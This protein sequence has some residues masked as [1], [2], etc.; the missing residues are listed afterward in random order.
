MIN[1]ST[2]VGTQNFLE[3][4]QAIF[5]KEDT[6]T[7]IDQWVAMS[8][9]PSWSWYSTV[10]RKSFEHGIP[11]TFENLPEPR[12][13]NK[14]LEATLHSDLLFSLTDIL[15]VFPEM[16]SDHFIEAL[17]LELPS[18]HEVKRI[19]KIQE[20]LATV[21]IIRSAQMPINEDILRELHQWF[22]SSSPQA[23]YNVLVS[24]RNVL[25]S[26][27]AIDTLYAI[28]WQY[29]THPEVYAQ[30]ETH[31]ILLKIAYE[32]S[33]DI[34][35]VGLLKKKDIL[36]LLYAKITDTPSQLIKQFLEAKSV[37]EAIAIVRE[38]FSFFNKLI[39]VMMKIIEDLAS[40]KEDIKYF[41]QNRLSLL[42]ETIQK[43]VRFRPNISSALLQIHNPHALKEVI[44]ANPQI[45]DDSILLSLNALHSQLEVSH[46]SHLAQ[47]VIHDESVRS[48]FS[49]F[50][51]LKVGLHLN[52]ESALQA[53]LR[54]LARYA[55]GGVPPA[56][57]QLDP[58]QVASWLQE[59][60]PGRL[61]VV[62]DDV[63]SPTLLKQLLNAL[64]P[65]A[66]FL[67]TTRD[68]LIAKRVTSQ[69]I[70]LET[71]TPE[72]GL[73]FL[74]ERLGIEP[75]SVYGIFSGKI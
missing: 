4:Y 36:E 41:M 1:T 27:E 50:I 52:E 32:Q 75:N 9:D 72:E 26:Q 5:L 34:A 71:F 18:V 55:F 61:F 29:L 42:Q 39:L 38:D 51:W 67:L 25:L 64:P 20:I 22:Q 21:R 65:K 33:I 28:K 24:K 16:I 6:L 46:K 11:S 66:C 49:S 54:N 43:E 35:Y 31:Y 14:A 74:T 44:L 10:L 37:F 30:L 8:G 70:C 68:F 73:Q 60:V 45:T 57:D 53:L 62:F 7:K 47:K 2:W 23:S 3:K 12:P 56:I 13:I 69:C 17:L 63:W 40:E 58:D 59:T 48:I 15:E 19:E